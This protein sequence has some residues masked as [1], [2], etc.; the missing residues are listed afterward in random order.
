MLSGSPRSA[1]AHF[2]DE[3][4][5]GEV[6]LPPDLELVAELSLEPSLPDSSP[7]PGISRGRK[8]GEGGCRWELCGN[9]AGAG[10][11]PRRS[12]QSGTVRSYDS[13]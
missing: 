8:E 5:H 10:E 13:L 6:N 12:A 2:A 3:E 9:T 11:P 1:E 7:C 4:L